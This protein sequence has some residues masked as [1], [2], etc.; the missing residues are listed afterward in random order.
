M[1]ED[2]QQSENVARQLTGTVIQ[3]GDRLIAVE[4]R[5]AQGWGAGVSELTEAV[6]RLEDR[7]SAVE[8]S[9]D[10]DQQAL[11]DLLSVKVEPGEEL[12]R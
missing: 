1:K 4:A 6:K 7:V 3:L 10:R 12:R 5:G 9:G 11:R 8:L 2:V